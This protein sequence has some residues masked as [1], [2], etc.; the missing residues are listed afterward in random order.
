MRQKKMTIIVTAI[1]LI[2][3]IAVSPAQAVIDPV[4]LTL[5]AAGALAVLITGNETVKHFDDASM[6]HKTVPEQKAKDNL[7]ASGNTVE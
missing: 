1:M 5:I 3:F 6:A 2:S 4:S 7:Q